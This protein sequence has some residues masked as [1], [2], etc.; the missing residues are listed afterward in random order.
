MR[1]D[2]P[3]YLVEVQGK[4]FVR[5]RYMLWPAEERGVFDASQSQ[6]HV[7]GGAQADS[8]VGVLPRKWE[9]LRLEKEKKEKNRL[10]NVSSQPRW[11]KTLRI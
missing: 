10:Q 4:I 9:R 2:K 11:G 7:Q 1:P 8:Q 3:S 5:A 6:V